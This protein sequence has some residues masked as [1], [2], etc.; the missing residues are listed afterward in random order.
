MKRRKHRRQT[1]AKL[2]QQ[3]DQFLEQCITLAEDERTDMAKANFTD[4]RRITIDKAHTTSMTKP[5]LGLT[6]YARNTKYGV[7]TAFK[8]AAKRLLTNEK[9]VTF[10]KSSIIHEA[11]KAHNVHLTYD[12]GADGHYLSEKDRKI[13]GLPILRTSTKK[14]RRSKRR[15]MQGNK[16]HSTPIQAV[17]KTSGKSRH[18]QQLPNFANECG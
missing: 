3:E 18:V 5:V 9:Q 13:A 14:S 7:C 11:T 10:G 12:S 16:R 2:A 15:Y 4:G 17:I 1:L 8:R 6:Q